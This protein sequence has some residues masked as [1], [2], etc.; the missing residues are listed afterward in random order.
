[1][2]SISRFLRMS[3]CSAQLIISLLSS[4]SANPTVFS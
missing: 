2:A 4:M 3:T 1:L